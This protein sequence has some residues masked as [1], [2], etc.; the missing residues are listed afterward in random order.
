MTLKIAVLAPIPSASIRTESSANPGER[1]IERKANF[2][3][4]GYSPAL[5]LP[6]MH[7]ESKGARTAARSNPGFLMTRNAT[8]TKNSKRQINNLIPEFAAI[9]QVPTQQQVFH[10][11]PVRAL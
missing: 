5:A 10:R 9:V 6:R 4:M 8:S 2:K 3:S 11:V 1:A 7:I